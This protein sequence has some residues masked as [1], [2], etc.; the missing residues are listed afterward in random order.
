MADQ[1]GSSDFESVNDGNGSALTPKTAAVFSNLNIVGPLAADTES[2]D[3]FSMLHK[4]KKLLY[5]CFQFCIYRFPEDV[6]ILLRILKFTVKAGL[7]AETGALFTDMKLAD[8][9]F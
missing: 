5:Q 3:P 1:S 9:F 8:T 2:T 6:F 4:S 7:P